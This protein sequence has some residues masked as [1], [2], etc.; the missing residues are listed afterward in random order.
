MLEGP[1]AKMTELGFP[2][3]LAVELQ[4][5]GLRLDSSLWTARLSNGGYS[6][7]LFW[8]SQ[9]RGPRRRRRRRKP[10]TNHQPIC[11]Q[12]LSGE[13]LR[14]SLQACVKKD[15]GLTATESP[16]NA[17]HGSK[18]ACVESQ[19]VN[20]LLAA[21]DEVLS[22]NLSTHSESQASGPEDPAP[23]SS[24]SDEENEESASEEISLKSCLE[25]HYEKRE[26]VHGVL[27]CDNKNKHK[28]TPVC[29]R[30][31][32]RVRLTEAQL[33]RVPAHCR[34]PPPS[35]IDT[36]SS[37][38]EVPLNIP[39]DAKVKFSVV[40]GAPGLSIA[41]NRIH[42]WTPIASRTRARSRNSN[43]I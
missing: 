41:T 3:S 34:P 29:R 12:N 6:V 31:R 5:R 27:V 37:G 35:D 39:E 18:P 4:C 11:S 10:K 17:H 15:F 36:S 38:S 42:T 19:T 43:N 30:R 32:K 26:G 16:I 23:T 28:W 8:P 9:R 40:D 14:Q 2:L 21:E 13:N 1:Y 7:S 22:A 20:E 24:D 33:Q 25:V